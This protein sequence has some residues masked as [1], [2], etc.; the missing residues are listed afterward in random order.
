MNLFAKTAVAAALLASIGAGAAY[1]HRDWHRGD[2]DGMM[3]Q[4]PMGGPMGGPMMARL[5][6]AK[7][8]ITGDRLA[9]RISERLQITDSQKPALKDLQ[10]AFAKSMTDA[11]ALCDE[12]PDFSTITGRVA[13]AQKRLSV[14]A[15]GLA[16]VRP[17]LEAFYASLD[18]NQKD[19]FNHMGPMGRHRRDGDGRWMDH[20]GWMNHGGWMDHRGG[21]WD[22]E[23]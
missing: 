22:S 4:G 12:K 9:A 20:R 11:K 14:M 5:C 15:A 21:G 18:D 2:R 23:D 7:D 10:E 8:P 16:N 3:G 1:A 13:F 19:K 6:T 17:K